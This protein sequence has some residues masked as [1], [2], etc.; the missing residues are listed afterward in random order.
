MVGNPWANEATDLPN[1]KPE[2]GKTWN[3][4]RDMVK[5][6]KPLLL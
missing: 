4:D 6:P 3:Y 5:T 2:L 1:S